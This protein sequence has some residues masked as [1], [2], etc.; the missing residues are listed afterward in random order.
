[1]QTIITAIFFLAA[2]AL[3]LATVLAPVYLLGKSLQQLYPRYFPW[4]AWRWTGIC[5]LP[6]LCYSLWRQSFADIWLL[7]QSL[8]IGSLGAALLLLPLSGIWF[9]WQLRGQSDLK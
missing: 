5:L 4:P 7:T 6:A 1:M 2:L 3:L 8:L 9:W